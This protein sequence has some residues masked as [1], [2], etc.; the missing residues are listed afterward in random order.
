MPDQNHAQERDIPWRRIAAEGGAIVISILLAFGIQAAWES[1]RDSV[2]EQDHLLALR[3]QF[4]TSLEMIQVEIAA[5][6]AAAE[7][8]RRLV[9]L[10]VRGAVA[11]DS[12]SLAALFTSSLAPG[13]VNLPSGALDA[14]LASGG[15]RLITDPEL[16]SRLAAWPSLVAEVYENAGWLLDATTQD[17]L[18]FLYTYVGGLS[19]AAGGPLDYPP[20]RFPSKTE[21]L[22][23]D[24][25]LEGHLYSRGFRLYQVLDRYSTLAGGADSILALIRE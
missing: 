8:T 14:L 22:F 10:D 7:A 6:E 3:S 11:L 18:P 9:A 16:A 20:T 2:E 25:L 23:S 17:Y 15:L 12:D 4:Q 24:P 13:R 1:R 21:Q 19:F 5:N